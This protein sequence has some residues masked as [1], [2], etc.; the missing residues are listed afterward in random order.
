MVI[1]RRSE[2]EGI[3]GCNTRVEFK[4]N[5]EGPYRRRAI[6][7]PIIGTTEAQNKFSVEECLRVGL[8]G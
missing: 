4:P 3:C 5:E 7:V 2:G 8:V 1:E 6:E